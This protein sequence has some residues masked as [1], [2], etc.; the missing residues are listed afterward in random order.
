M[1]FRYEDVDQALCLRYDTR[2]RGQ[3]DRR[4]FMMRAQETIPEIIIQTNEG[5]E[6]I[7]TIEDLY[8]SCYYPQG[9]FIKEDVTCNT[10]FMLE[11]K[12]TI[13]AKICQ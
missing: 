6:Q 7:L 9:S 13:S 8:L 5:I 4:T 10:Q 12:L 1:V 3:G 2:E 11:T